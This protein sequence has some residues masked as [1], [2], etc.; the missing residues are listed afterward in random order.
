MS[1][2]CRR[3]RYRLD[4]R[5]NKMKMIR[6][7]VGSI[8]AAVALFGLTV[9]ATASV[10]LGYA[11]DCLTFDTELSSEME[12][13]FIVDAADVISESDAVTLAGMDTNM[14]LP[15]EPLSAFGQETDP[16]TIRAAETGIMRGV[17]HGSIATTSNDSVLI[18]GTG[19]TSG[20]MDVTS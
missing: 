5:R 10:G 8:F 3:D 14:H 4:Q 2:H 15:L 12:P 16:V 17:M 18:A 19:Y 9:P 20:V 13:T 1:S 11:L 7:L 6:G